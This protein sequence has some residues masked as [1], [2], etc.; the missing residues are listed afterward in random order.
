MDDRLLYSFILMVSLMFLCLLLP[1]DS[2][3][4][5][6]IQNNATT[7]SLDQWLIAYLLYPKLIAKLLSERGAT[8]QFIIDSNQI[9]LVDLKR[10]N[11]TELL[12][13]VEFSS[14]LS[15]EPVADYRVA[16]Q[17]DALGNMT[18]QSFETVTIYQEDEA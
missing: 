7:D 6:D 8:S 2:K 13:T 16:Y 5:K 12:V 3:E 17:I 11:D 15:T 14:F 9:K 10:A 4:R 1:L 18:T